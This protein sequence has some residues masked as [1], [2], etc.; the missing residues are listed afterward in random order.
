MR[1]FS[2][3]RD[4][5]RSR[6]RV[7]TAPR[8]LTYIVTFA[9]NARCVM[10]DSWRKPSDDDL[11]TEETDRIFS[12]LPRMDVVR[13]TGGEPFLRK[14]LVDIAALAHAH[15]RPLLL[16]VT[17]NGFLTNRI[18]EFCER[19]PRDLP[20]ALLVSID[21]LRDKHNA[22]RGREK[23]FEFAMQTLEA[24]APRRRELRLRL[25][26]NQTITDAE[27]AAQYRPLRE[28]LRPL[29]IAN[30]IVMA[31]DVSATYSAEREIEAAPR[32]IGQFVPWGEFAAD[33]L[34]ALLDEAEAGLGELPWA[35][36]IAKRYYLSGI[37][38]RLLG[39]RGEPNPPCVALGAHIRLYP[40]GDVPVCQFNSRRV[41]NLREQT[42]R[43]VWFGDA[44]GPHRQWVR[45]CPGCWAECEV[46]P[47]AIYTGNL[48]RSAFQCNNPSTVETSERMGKAGHSG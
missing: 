40:N 38:N 36:R 31:Y 28:A 29:G 34:R 43:D 14:D 47:N 3:L 42:F 26:V 33:Q 15:L 17:T 23:A 39:G 10:C 22:I 6:R 20:L 35:E 46:L 27:G 12:Q 48:L 37:R 2:F 9:C 11:T 24:L 1:L 30:H 19:R 18:V 25:A 45:R 16:H 13:L 4:I 41:G 21:G 44:I 32:E 7:P 8:Y 5:L